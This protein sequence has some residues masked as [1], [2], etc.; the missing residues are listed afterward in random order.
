M[1]NWI[2]WGTA[3]CFTIVMVTGGSLSAENLV[4]VNLL[5]DHDTPS[6][7]HDTSVDTS[8]LLWN[9]YNFLAPATNARWTIIMT[10]NAARIDRN[11]LVSMSPNTSIEYA[12]SGNHSGEKMSTMSYAQQKTELE[13]AKKRAEL[14]KICGVN[15]VIVKGFMPQ[16]YDQNKDTYKALDDLGIVY[17]AG[18][19]AGVLY[20]PGHENDVW[21]Y[22]VEDHN[23]YAVPIST[24]TFSGEKV[25]L[26]DREIKEKGLS[27]SKWYDLLVGKFDEV[28]GKDEPMV[29][30]LHSSIS[31][32]GDYLDALKQF[33][34]YAESH[35]AGFVTASD[36]IDMS[37]T[38]D[39]S[40][41]PSSPVVSNTNAQPVLESE[42]NG[43]SG[44]PECDKMQNIT[45]K[46]ITV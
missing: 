45:A 4:I 43:T 23:F 20:A 26:D 15:E 27:S 19:K 31:G 18:F 7:I 30:S 32:T 6:S 10:E 21:P 42:K 16:L 17:D 11:T 37:I 22:K 25:A 35:K 13:N 9:M 5:V 44:C 41:V 12:I 24:Y 38:G 8:Q 40:K 2:F 39:H 34:K 33:I 46:V 3:I 28:S 29:I 36:L 1:N 14:C